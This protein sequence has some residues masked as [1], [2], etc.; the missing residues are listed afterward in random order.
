MEEM[1]NQPGGAPEGGEEKKE[2]MEG[3]PAAAPAE[4]GD[5]A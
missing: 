3:Q 5:A 2:G 4:G 1:E